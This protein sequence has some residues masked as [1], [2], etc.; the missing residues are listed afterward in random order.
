MPT[1][2]VG[3]LA[4]SGSARHAG[5]LVL[6]VVCLLVYV[7]AI[8][9]FAALVSTPWSD[10]THAHSLAPHHSLAALKAALVVVVAQ[11]NCEVVLCKPGLKQ[12]QTIPNQMEQFV[13]E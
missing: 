4:R 12:V 10:A 3:L 9:G 1:T 8:I 2:V 11:V 6:V 13:V 7:V 5:R